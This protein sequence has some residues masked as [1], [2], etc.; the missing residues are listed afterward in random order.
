M[1]HLKYQARQRRIAF[2][3]FCF[4]FH[5]WHRSDRITCTSWLSFSMIGH[6]VSRSN[7][8]PANDPSQ[9]PEINPPVRDSVRKTT[10]RRSSAWVARC[11]ARL[12]H[13]AQQLGPLTSPL[14]TRWISSGGNAA[15]FFTPSRPRS[16]ARPAPQADTRLT[17][18]RRH[19]GHHPCGRSKRAES[20]GTPPPTVSRKRAGEAR[21]CRRRESGGPS[22]GMR[23]NQGMSSRVCCGITSQHPTRGRAG[24]PAA[25]IITNDIRARPRARNLPQSDQPRA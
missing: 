24:K 5:C 6:A 11:A 8:H 3:A 14:A 15:G 12:E 13:R 18:P 10:K 7:D 20:S 4:G 21:G 1:K 17:R 19:V 23:S 22:Q 16:G 2:R 9:S 25:A